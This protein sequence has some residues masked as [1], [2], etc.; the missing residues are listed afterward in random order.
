MSINVSEISLENELFISKTKPTISKTIIDYSTYNNY[1]TVKTISVEIPIITYKKINKKNIVFLPE[2]ADNNY[3]FTTLPAHKLT[4][5]L[6]SFGFP[7][8]TQADYDTAVGLG[9]SYDGDFDNTVLE[10]ILQFRY[11]NKFRNNLGKLKDI[12]KKYPHLKIGLSVGGGIMSW[13]FSKVLGNTT[14]RTNFVNSI[15]GYIIREGLDEIN[16]D[17]EYPKFAAHSYSLFDANNDIPNYIL[18]L[19]ELRTLLDDT[20]TYK[21]IPISVDTGNYSSVIDDF[22]GMNSLIDYYYIMTYDYSGNSWEEGNPQTAL[23]EFTSGNNKYTSKSVELMNT[24][25]KIPKD[26]I[27]IGA[28]SYGWGFKNMDK[29]GTTEYYGD[30]LSGGTLPDD[31]SGGSQTGVELYKNIVNKRDTDI[32]YTEIYDATTGSVHLEKDNGDG[33][34]EIWTYDNHQTVALKSQYINTNNLAGI[35]NWNITGDT[36]DEDT[37]LIHSVYSNF[38]NSDKYNVSIYANDMEKIS[39]NRQGWLGLGTQNPT[40]KLDVEGGAKIN[41]D[42]N[43]TGNLTYGGNLNPPS[44]DLKIEADQ[45]NIILSNT[46]ETES[47]IQF[48][49]SSSP[50]QWFK[51]N[52]NAATQ[53]LIIKSDTTDAIVITPDGVVEITDTIKFTNL[54]TEPTSTSNKLYLLNGVL[55]FGTQTVNLT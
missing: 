53:N 15:V 29:L 46:T 9:F 17:W 1:N 8:F 47:G 19:T 39:I 20:S 27:C 45:P 13:N 12:K 48:I 21:Y 36:I 52:F 55:K 6:L 33:T 24:I 49:D 2:N 10:G 23:Y 5:V 54:I 37:S 30:D 42:C 31:F 25:S 35:I 7:N 28:A 38:L 40:E 32:N 34:H 18:F 14:T 50:D 51:I 22:I 26:K 4:H 11:T 41:G 43:I 44:G 16:I 3:D